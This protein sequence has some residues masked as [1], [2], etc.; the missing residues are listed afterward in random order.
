MI[1]IMEE[2]PTSGTVKS[3]S[4]YR[5]DPE[6]SRDL[7]IFTSSHPPVEKVANGDIHE[8]R[9]FGNQL[10]INMADHLPLN[11]HVKRQNFQLETK[12]GTSISMR[13][14]SIEEKNENGPAVVFVHGG[15]RVFGS[16]DLYDQVVADY[17]DRS[18][19]PFLSVDYHLVPETTGRVQ[20][21]EVL[22]VILWLKANA[23]ALGVDKDRIGIMGD[24]GGGG[25]AAGVAILAR[26][27]NIGLAKQILIY[28]M[29][30]HRS[31]VLNEKIEPFAVFGHVELS[32][33]WP[34]ILGSDEL[35]EYDKIIVSPSL[36]EDFDGLTPVYIAIGDLDY[37]RDESI[38]YARKLALAGVP[39]EF[40]VFPGAPHGFEIFTPNTEMSK[41]AMASHVRAIR[42]F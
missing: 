31:S 36:L 22:D 12:E 14:Y 34:A 15:G 29:L 7:A 21:E 26:D 10:Y 9:K 16:L 30:D 41:I 18:K 19:V 23:T 11:E 38:E 35:N 25:I 40:H 20:N 3:A 32:L 2:K 6:I 27:Q 8:L 13:W 37:F 4:A 28:P 5:L 42:S 39:L 24:S 17:V 33:L 1:K